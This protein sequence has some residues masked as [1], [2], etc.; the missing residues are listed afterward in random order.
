MRRRRYAIAALL[1]A[2]LATTL[3]LPVLAADP[4]ADVVLDGTVTVTFIDPE[5]DGPIADA[6]ITL[7][8]R[9]P[10]LGE[11]SIIQTLTGQTDADGKAVLT[12]VARPDDGAPPVEADGHGAQGRARTAAAAWWRPAARPTLPARSR[13]RSRSWPASP[14]PA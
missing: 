11:D 1:A 7:V 3:A 12:S 2:L 8:A 6:H 14:A 13:W 4:P 10:D 9:R 5:D